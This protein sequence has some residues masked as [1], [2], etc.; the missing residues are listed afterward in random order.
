MHPTY[1]LSFV[2]IARYRVSGGTFTKKELR[3]LATPTNAI[4][5]YFSTVKTCVLDL[6]EELAL[7]T[8]ETAVKSIADKLLS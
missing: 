1:Q 2:P 8:V 5:K 6:V 4:A 7:K 3:G